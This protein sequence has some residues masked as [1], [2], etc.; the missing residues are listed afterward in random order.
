MRVRANVPGVG[1]W[2]APFALLSNSR[3]ARSPAGTL[4]PATLGPGSFHPK[5]Y[6]T[7]NPISLVAVIEAAEITGPGKN[8]IDFCRR[9]AQPDF[10]QALPQVDATIVT[11]Q[12][13]TSGGGQP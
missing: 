6:F 4:S 13:H 2:T 5:R 8:L 9:A 11:Y 3:L 7:M 1:G 10:E 12:R